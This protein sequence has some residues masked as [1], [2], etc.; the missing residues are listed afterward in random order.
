MSSDKEAGDSQIR[1]IRPVDAK[2][3]VKMWRNDQGVT[4]KVT[5]WYDEVFSPVVERNAKDGKTSCEVPFTGSQ[6]DIAAAVSTLLS[7]GWGVVVGPTTPAE[8]ASNTA[9]LQVSWE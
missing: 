3:L 2:W 1:G 5:K 9:L 7:S 8:G 4:E 6:A